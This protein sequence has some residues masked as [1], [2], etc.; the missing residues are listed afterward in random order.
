VP[1]RLTN[2]LLLVLAA[3]L[4]L[5]GLLGWA[6]PAEQAAPFYPAH[7][8]LGLALLL[9]LGW[10]QAIARRSLRRRLLRPR[11]DRSVIPGLV[12]G[13]LLLASVALGLGWTLGLVSFDSLWGYSALNLHVQLALALLP[14]LLWHLARRWEPPPSPRLLVTRRAALRLIGLGL[15]TSLALPL[16]DRAALARGAAQVRRPTGSKP[17]GSFSGNDFPVTI[18]LFDAIPSLD[19][20][21]WRLVLDGRVEAPAM[22]SYQD[23]LALS[24][25]TLTTVLDCTGGW[26]TEQTWRGVSLGELLASRGVDPGARFVEVVSVTGHRWLFPLAELSQALLATDVGGEVLSP[27]HG[28]P[29]RLVAP[30]R[31]GFQWIKW[32]GRVTVR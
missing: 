19:P 3:G 2:L 20:T 15:A 7:R 14:F 23:L 18:W 30:G 8:G 17:A 21:T 16:L 22:L 6:L 28:Y 29:L 11:W 27:G 5:T 10:K 1:R 13:A 12:G 24:R 32:V 9:T 4:V 26:W 25:R 31:R